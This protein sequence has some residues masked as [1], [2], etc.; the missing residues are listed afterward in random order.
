MRGI[1]ERYFLYLKS[2]RGIL[3][4]PTT[5]IGCMME[6]NSEGIDTRA[7]A[8]ISHER[9]VKENSKAKKNR[10]RKRGGEKERERK[11]FHRILVSSF[12]RA[13]GKSSNTQVRVYLCVRARLI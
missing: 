8:Y 1:S 4:E 12:S 3:T 9:H 11:S 2:S 13:F 5:S 7:N 10:E 6:T